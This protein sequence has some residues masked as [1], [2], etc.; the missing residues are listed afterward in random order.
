MSRALRRDYDTDPERWRTGQ[1]VVAAYLKGGDVHGRVGQR[2]QD[3]GAAS[4]LD[5]GCGYGRLAAA[6]PPGIRWIGCD[7]SPTMLGEAPRPAVRA[8]AVRLPFG[9]GTFDAAAAMYML[10]HLEDPVE[11]IREAH[12]VLRP[13]GIFAASAPSRYD[14]PE[15]SSIVA[16]VPSTFDAETAPG[17]IG[18]VFEKVEVFAWDTPAYELPDLE[19]LRQYLR[20]WGHRVTGDPASLEF[21]LTLTKRGAVVYGIKAKN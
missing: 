10:Y 15:L 1:R 13:G 6:L 17:Q 3:A 7:M 16:A 14:T 19:A 8:D 21:P 18:A 12:R 2:L 5:I 9:A 4:V 20:G 11:G